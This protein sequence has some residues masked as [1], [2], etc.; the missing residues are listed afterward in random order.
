M[1]LSCAV[2]PADQSLTVLV[3]EDH[4]NSFYLKIF[5]L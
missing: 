4:Q 5:F 1:G 3:L 2:K